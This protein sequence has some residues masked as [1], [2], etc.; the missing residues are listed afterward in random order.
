[1]SFPIRFCRQDANVTEETFSLYFYSVPG[2]NG[3]YVWYF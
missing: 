3:Q 2:L 1:V